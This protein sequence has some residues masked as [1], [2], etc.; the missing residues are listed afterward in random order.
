MPG[1]EATLK[2]AGKGMTISSGIMRS[3]QGSGRGKVK[4]RAA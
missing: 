2:A 1:Q 3:P 4:G